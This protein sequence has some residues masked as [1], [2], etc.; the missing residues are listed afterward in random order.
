MTRQH[1]II[2]VGAGPV[3][4]TLSALMARAGLDVVLLEGD[5]DLAGDPRASTFHAPT[6]DMLDSIGAA[7]PILDQGVIVPRW[8]IRMHPQ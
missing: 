6:L 5:K 8:Q 3:G 1:D 4:L 7:Q 2:I